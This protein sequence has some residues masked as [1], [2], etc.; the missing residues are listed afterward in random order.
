MQEKRDPLRRLP[1]AEHLQM[2]LVAA[3][4][5]P[6]HAHQLPLQPRQLPRD[7]LELRERDLAH[8][9]PRQRDRVDRV[10]AGAE[11]VEPDQ[12]AGQMEADHLRDAVVAFRHRLE[13][14]LARD[15]QRRQRRVAPVQPV[16]RKQ[17]PAGAH[18]VVEAVQ[19]VVADRR[20]QAQL[21]QRTARAAPAQV[22][23]V[24]A[25]GGAHG[26]VIPSST[27]SASR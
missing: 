13:R 20:R 16:A 2:R 7:A 18:D 19:V 5:L 27:A 26:P 9:R 22:L 11:P 10:L 8:L 24:E 6:D 25:R 15:V 14:A 4:A 12:L 3:D 21:V 23:E 17:R 1:A